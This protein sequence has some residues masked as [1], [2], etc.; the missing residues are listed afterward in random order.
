MARGDCSQ[1]DKL[2]DPNFEPL[3]SQ[4]VIVFPFLMALEIGF[5]FIW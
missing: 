2:S 3:V 1:M 5:S 4:L